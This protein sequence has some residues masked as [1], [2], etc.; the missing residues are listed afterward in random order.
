MCLPEPTLPL[1]RPSQELVLVR[2]KAGSYIFGFH[3]IITV[4][5]LF[6]HWPSTRRRKKWIL[7][8]DSLKPQQGHSL[9]PN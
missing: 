2:D 4:S 1:G 7:F 5:P 8:I 6:I 3:V 9:K